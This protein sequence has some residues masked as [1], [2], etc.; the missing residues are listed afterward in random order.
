MRPLE[1]IAYRSD[2]WH[3]MRRDSVGGSDVGVILGLSPFASREQLL[4]EKLAGT[5]IP[6]SPAMEAGLLLEPM[7]ARR[8]AEALGGRLLDL[9]EG[10]WRDGRQHYT[11]DGVLVVNDEPALLEVKTS[12]FASAKHGWGDPSPDRYDPDAIPQHHLAQVQHGLRLSGLTHGWLALMPRV[13][14]DLHLWRIDAD[15]AIQALIT[16]EADAFLRDLDTAR[17]DQAA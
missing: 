11:P 3:E 6:T 10:V 12:A 2:E 14:L 13:S 9:P 5:R 4:A 8:A 7:V 1:P 17:E 16:R 15:R